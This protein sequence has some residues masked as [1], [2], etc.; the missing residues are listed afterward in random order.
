MDLDQQVKLLRTAQ[1]TSSIDPVQES[2]PL[3]LFEAIRRWIDGEG[4]GG[5]DIELDGARLTLEQIQQIAHSEDY[6]A[7]LLAFDER[8]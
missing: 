1:P 2:A 3:A 7:R 6:K 5:F 4:M 8:R